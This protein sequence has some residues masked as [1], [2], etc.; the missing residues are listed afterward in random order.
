MYQRHSVILATALAIALGSH[1]PLAWADPEEAPVRPP[2]D[3][4][5]DQPEV[6][7]VP[8]TDLFE[9][10]DPEA[11]LE[12]Q[13]RLSALRQPLV[14]SNDTR[15]PVTSALLSGLAV[16]PGIGQFVNG[17]W[18]KGLLVLGTGSLLVAGIQVGN[19]RKNPSLVTTATY[20]LYP[21]V[22]FGTVDAIATSRRRP[23]FE[24][25]ASD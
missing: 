7:P 24:T 18:L 6:Q 11:V 13:R 16:L 5:V 3:F 1:A 21:L 22:L 19:Q 23:S 17:E 20:G 14:T 4:R 10:A 15:Q 2:I 9:E 25:T 8:E 12:E